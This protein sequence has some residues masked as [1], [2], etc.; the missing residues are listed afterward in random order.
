MHC[1]DH[2]TYKGDRKIKRIE[3]C[4]GCKKAREAWLLGVK[5]RKNHGYGGQF[6]ITT[7]NFRCSIAHLLSELG[8]I[9]IYGKQPPFF[10]RK[11]TKSSEVVKKYFSK[12]FNLINTQFSKQPE[13]Y[14]FVKQALWF[15]WEKN[16]HLIKREEEH[17]LSVQLLEEQKE[18]EIT[19]TETK[20]NWFENIHLNPFT[21]GD[22]LDGEKEKE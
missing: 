14:R 20:D 17:K 10:W 7:P 16:Y 2:P 1:P 9:V 11:E 4:E 13:M 12:T 18:S 6:S 5:K 21:Y 8:T 22:I 19:K 3:K 15:V